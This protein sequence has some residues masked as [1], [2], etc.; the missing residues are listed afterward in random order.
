MED[1]VTDYSTLELDS[2]A[3]MLLLG[4]DCFVFDGIIGNTCNVAPFDP[5][6]GTAEKIPIV[7]GA[8]AYDCQ[9]THK[10]YILLS[11]N[12]LYM[13][14][15]DHSSVPSFIMREAGLTC[16]ETPKIHKE[17]PDIEDHSIFIP[18][19]EL[20]IPLQLKGT[21]SYFNVRK[22]TNEEIINCDK[23]FITP[24]SNKWDPYS[25]IM[26]RMSKQC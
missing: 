23:A 7:D 4:K 18:D 17:S 5:S 3:N 26:L 25:I 13:L 16:H 14:S 11:R 24:D 12:A 9:Y 22:P 15:L 21:F 20:R 19:L 8:L 1:V 6:L 10:T 2:H